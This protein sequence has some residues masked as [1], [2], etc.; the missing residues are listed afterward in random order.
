MTQ[1][2]RWPLIQLIILANIITMPFAA[3]EVFKIAEK[4]IVLPYIAWGTTIFVGLLKIY[5]SGLPRTKW[6]DLLMGAMFVALILG[7]YAKRMPFD[8]VLHKSFTQGIYLI[9]MY[10]GFKCLETL[11]KQKK[12]RRSWKFLARAYVIAAA[13]MTLWGICQ[14]V[15]W[16]AFRIPIDFFRTANTYHLHQA[17]E[18][19]NWTGISVR[20]FGTFPEPLNY[21]C[22]LVIALVLV[23]SK[24]VLER[25]MRRATSALLGIGILLSFSRTAFFCVLTAFLVRIIIRDKKGGKVHL[26]FLVGFLC[27]LLAFWMI[28]NPRNGKWD[29]SI[30]GR[31]S[32]IERTIKVLKERPWFGLGLGRFDTLSARFGTE[33]HFSRARIPATTSVFTKIFM[34]GGL[35]GGCFLGLFLYFLAKESAEG[36]PEFPALVVVVALYWMGSAGWNM[37]FVWIGLALAS[38]HNGI[39]VK[40]EVP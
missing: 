16:E 13:V 25:T 31:V 15:A 11:L 40:R 26:R 30:K 5:K 27:V 2:R 19:S 10:T 33:G 12:I 34:E 18:P 20:A 9:F 29:N 36:G 3:M 4:S 35:A 39:P 37:T 17:V 7:L 23:L 32:E 24:D 22:F 28:T 21:G 6:S 8:T 38:S 14:V 1:P